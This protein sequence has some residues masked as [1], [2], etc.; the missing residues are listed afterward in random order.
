MTRP[1]FSIVIPTRNRAHLVP[2]AIRS[3]L[4]QTFDDF[5]LV[6]VD[7]ASTDG[8]DQA[9]R[10]FKDP[11]IRAIHS[12]QARLMHDNWTFALSLAR[13]E[14]VLFL[15]DDDA[16]HPRLLDIV[17]R[18]IEL[19]NADVVCWRSITHYSQDW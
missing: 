15:C 8:T 5:E 19:F 11:R 7:N 6:V 1:R 9:I 14:Y 3:A 13:G 10:A 2:C 4:A 12:N 17:D 18:H 16:W